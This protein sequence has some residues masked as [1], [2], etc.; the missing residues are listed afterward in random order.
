MQRGRWTEC[1]TKVTETQIKPGELLWRSYLWVKAHF[2]ET[3]V[4]LWAYNWVDAGATDWTERHGND[5]KDAPL[6]HPSKEHSAA[7]QCRCSQLPCHQPQQANFPGSQAGTNS[8]A[9]KSNQ[10]ADTGWQSCFSYLLSNILL[11]LLFILSTHF[12]VF[13]VPAV[14]CTSSVAKHCG[15][16]GCLKASDTDMIWFFKCKWQVFKVKWHSWNSTRVIY[17]QHNHAVV[18]ELR[19]LLLSM[20]VL[21]Q[22]KVCIF[23]SGLNMVSSI[24]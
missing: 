1:K 3:F 23:Y 10:P 7:L 2:A 19:G 5:W 8:K 9:T 13:D 15:G 14:L 21:M 12:E 20:Y 11:L 18:W 4:T 17:Y 16:A 24:Y 22:P 6:L